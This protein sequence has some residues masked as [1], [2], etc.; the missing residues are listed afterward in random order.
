MRLI[1]TRDYRQTDFALSLCRYVAVW[2]GDQRERIGDEVYV[3]EI[4]DQNLL[5]LG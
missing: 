4:P 2:C 3:C 5:Y 1:E